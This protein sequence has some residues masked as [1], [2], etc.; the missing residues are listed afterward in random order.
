[1]NA[2]LDTL[3]HF[4]HVLGAIG[5]L[6]GGLMLTL[7]GL[8]ARSSSSPQAA[9]EFARTLPYVGPR[10]LLPSSLVVPTTGVWMVLDSSAWKFSQLWVVLAI[11][12]FLVALAV[13]ALYVGRV[14][15]QL[16]RATE[17]GTASTAEMA[18]LLRRWLLGYGM[19]LAVLLVAVWDMVFKP[20]LA[21]S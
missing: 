16:A 9:A 18:L 20:G 3:L 12:L 5:W 15:I 17:S 6:G 8:R 19:V 4:I 13:G 14:G 7:V 1:M 21:G 11:A 2:T 10:V